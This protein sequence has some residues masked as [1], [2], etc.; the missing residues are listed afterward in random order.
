[1]VGNWGTLDTSP[2]LLASDSVIGSSDWGFLGLV[3]AYLGIE[4][5]DG[6][7]DEPRPEFACPF[8]SE[9]FDV[10]GLCCHMDDEH[11]VE[12]KN[13]VLL[14]SSCPRELL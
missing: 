8:C 4:E 11:P 5:L 7:E 14:R 10:V 9:V 6:G 3:D 2:A 12:A 13:G 1:M